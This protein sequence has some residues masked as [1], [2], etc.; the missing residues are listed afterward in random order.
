MAVQETES[1]MEN[2]D[3][4]RRIFTNIIDDVA[5]T[6][7]SRVVVAIPRSST[8]QDGWKD[9]SY[10]QYA[11]AI[12]RLCHWI[13]AKAGSSLDGQFPTFA[14]IGPND[15]RYFIFVAAATKCQFQVSI[16]PALS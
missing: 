2:P 9:V 13:V 12:N 10:S 14:Y 11:N 5:R 8:P 3:Y 16:H 1:S 7:P 15:I 6:D 4:G